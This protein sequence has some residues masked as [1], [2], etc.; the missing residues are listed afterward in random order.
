MCN[1]PKQTFLER[2]HTNGHKAYEITINIT[3][4]QGNANQNYKEISHHASKNDHYG[5]ITG[6]GED[7]KQQGGSLKS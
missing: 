7:G 1:R 2:R 5:K 6:A 4:G 3:D